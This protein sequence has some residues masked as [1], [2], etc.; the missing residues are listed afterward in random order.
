MLRN[1]DFERHPSINNCNSA[2]RTS[3]AGRGSWSIKTQC[4]P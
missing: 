1:D 3:I 4:T 2:E